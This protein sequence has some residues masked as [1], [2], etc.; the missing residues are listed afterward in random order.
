MRKVGDVWYVD[1]TDR[2]PEFIPGA[3]ME[4]ELYALTEEQARIDAERVL[5]RC[6]VTER[7]IKFD[8]VDMLVTL[9]DGKQLKFWAS[10]YGGVR[11]VGEV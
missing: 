2:V 4:V 10:D 1:I 9:P 8:E 6:E 7:S 3:R 11:I 5:K